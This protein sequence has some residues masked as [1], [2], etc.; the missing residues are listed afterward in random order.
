MRALAH[1]IR[2]AILELL[3]EG[4]TATATEC[5]RQ[6]GESPQACSYHLR[7]LAKWGLVRNVESPD[8]RETRWGPAALSIRFSS[9]VERTP[10]FA[11]AAGAL[12]STVL[13]RD[14]RIVT[15]FLAREHE[16][17]LEWREA[18]TFSSGFVQVTAEELEELSRRIHELRSEFAKRTTT[19][20]PEGARRVD[21]IVRL[22]PQVGDR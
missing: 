11:A 9:D 6:V 3:Y 13:D 12:K 14:E 16:L 8:G 22:I 21:V 18:A 17:S 20:R 4:G 5:S 10:G 15:E 1:P 7:A 2:L 19:N